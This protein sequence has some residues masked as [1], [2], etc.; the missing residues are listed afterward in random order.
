L[1]DGTLCAATQP[2]S[3]VAAGAPCSLFDFDNNGNIIFGIGSLGRN[4]GITHDFASFDLRVTRAIR[5]GEKVRVD[6]IA[7][8][9]NL[10]NRFNE[11]SA[12]PFFRAVNATGERSGGK[13]FSRSTAAYDPRQFQLGIK[14]NF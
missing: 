8:G 7:E 6:L 1:P 12:S 14:V 10:F 4:R 5:F 13:Y 9:F 2:T 3:A 11:G